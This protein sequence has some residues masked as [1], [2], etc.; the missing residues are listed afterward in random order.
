MADRCYDAYWFRDGLVEK[1]I[2]PCIPSQK[3][4]TTPV[5]YDKH[6]YRRRN[7][8]EIMFWL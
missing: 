8:I 5:S 3:S 4:R 6:K 2:S 7:R 1:G